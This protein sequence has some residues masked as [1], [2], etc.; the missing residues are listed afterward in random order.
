NNINDRLV[1]EV[2]SEDYRDVNEEKDSEK[3]VD[4]CVNYGLVEDI[5]FEE[6]VDSCVNESQEDESDNEKYKDFAFLLS[7][8]F[9]LLDLIEQIRE[10]YALK[11]Q[12]LEEEV[13][14]V[15]RLM[16]S[17]DL[18]DMERDQYILGN[19]NESEKKEWGEYLQNKEGKLIWGQFDE[20]EDRL[21]ERIVTN[22]WEKLLESPINLFLYL[23]PI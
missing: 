22:T 6:D 5:E 15:D 14:L 9:K 20:I 11:G 18:E 19:S 7:S 21:L 23:N 10:E 12:E 16:R 2:A 13:K 8:H 4:S 1:K 17:L 3:D